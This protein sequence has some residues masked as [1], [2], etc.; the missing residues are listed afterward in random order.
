MSL[1]LQR[2]AGAAQ[3]PQADTAR[4]AQLPAAGNFTATKQR[5]NL[6]ADLAFWAGFYGPVLN[7]V[8]PRACCWQHPRERVWLGR[9]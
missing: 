8:L 4:R 6:C 1:A 3:S 5:A 2:R 7:F 9:R